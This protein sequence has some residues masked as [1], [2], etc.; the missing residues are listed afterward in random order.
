MKKRLSF[1]VLLVT[2]AVLLLSIVACNGTVT[3]VTTDAGTSADT[4]AVTP[5]G[6]SNITY[7]DK[8]AVH[9]NKISEL[10]KESDEVDSHAG[11]EAYSSLELNKREY[12]SLGSF[13]L[14]GIATPYYP[15]VRKLN[16]GSYIMSYH[17]TR[18]GSTVY[19][20]TS[21]NGVSWSAP[22]AV[23]SAGEHP[24]YDDKIYYMTPD[25]CVLKDGTI[26]LVSAFR[27]NTNYSKHVDA[28]GLVITMSKDNG[29]TWSSPQKIYTGTCWE[30]FIM[31]T[32]SGEIQVYFTQTGHLLAIHGWS[33]DRRS[34]CVGLLRSNDGGKTWTQCVDYSAQIVMQEFVYH[35][36][37][38]DYMN[39]QMPVA[40][41]LN[42]GTIALVAEY[43]NAKDSYKL[44]FAYSTDNWAKS[45]G[46]NEVG[47]ST[48]RGSVMSGA[49][50]YIDQF[51]SGETV[52]SAHGTK[53]STY[54][55]SSNAT[56]FKNEY[57]PFPENKGHWSSVFVDSS[58]SVI[59]TMAATLA[60]TTDAPTSTAIDVGR[61]YLNHVIYAKGSTITL[62]GKTDDWANN[63]SA[64]FIGSDSQA[65]MSMRFSY[66]E[67]YVY[68]LY[69][70]L[71]DYLMEGDAEGIYIPLEGNRYYL[72]KM[73]IDGVTSSFY[74]DGENMI[75]KNVEG[76]EFAATIVGGVGDSSKDTGK[77]LEIA[78]PRSIVSFAS[79][80]VF[81]FNA[82]L[83]NTDKNANNSDNFSNVD[84]TARNT[85]QR[86]YLTK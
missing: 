30:P 18:L 78:I 54:I 36:N 74:F 46:F 58:H 59:G 56:N 81:M 15:R 75:K 8:G 1:L 33:A 41:E 21:K 44:S 27:A 52:L 83:Y 77:I 69:E 17:A 49:G 39:D 29:R 66:D 24:T 38:Y 11:L 28:N 84:T 62:D 82:T 19:V 86:I 20:V 26:I 76:L 43:Y 42:N 9:I 63:T 10:N 51:I 47:P 73:G 79:D 23:L 68:V 5:D 40:V 61:M 2:L 48:L 70:R 7:V 45:L 4:D 71:D 12:A 22:Q 65:Q 25:L 80:G 55:G 53:M 14:G 60:G 32:S 13:D 72:I 34:S 67:N 50:P 64:L 16:D 37:G 6:P 85:W 3:D 35:K 57:Q 31:Q